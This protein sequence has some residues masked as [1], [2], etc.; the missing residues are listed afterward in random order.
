MGDNTNRIQPKTVFIIATILHLVIG[1]L[2]CILKEESFK[3]AFGVLAVGTV[4][5][6]ILFALD[7]GEKGIVIKVYTALAA[8][9]AVYIGVLVVQKNQDP[10]KYLF[11]RAVVANNAKKY[12]EYLTKYPHGEYREAALDSL[13]AR[14][15]D[16]VKNRTYNRTGLYNFI[17]T[18]SRPAIK[19]R[20][21]RELDKLYDQFK[22]SGTEYPKEFLQAY[23]HNYQTGRHISE[24]KKLVYTYEEQDA[25]DFAVKTAT[26]GAY[27]NFLK[28]FPDGPHAQ[29]IKRL[30][31]NYI[32]DHKYDGNYL[33]TGSQPYAN[34]YGSNSSYGN[35]T[36]TVNASGSTDVVVIVKRNNRYGKVAGHAYI[37][38]GGS[39][40]IHLSPGTYQTFFYYGTSWNPTKKLDNGLTGGFM[41]DEQYGQD[42]SLELKVSYVGDYIYYDTMTYSLQSVIGGNFRMS[43]SSA[44][45]VF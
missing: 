9:L 37:H 29:E 24:V 7:K 16:E 20:A 44:S 14:N 30:R 22:S 40:T 45:A 5:A 34:V 4:I 25:Y 35:C 32:K 18:C 19:N 23:A 31:Q 15:F 42:N 39:Y 13:A 1:I 27:D 6:L 26:K 43:D 41:Y 28:E 10:E 36:I 12:Q 21:C 33:R 17:D 11:R 3:M 38:K 8:C 2:Y